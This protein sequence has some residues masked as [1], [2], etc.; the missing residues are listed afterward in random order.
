MNVHTQAHEVKFYNFSY[1][2]DKVMHASSCIGI[3]LN[4]DRYSLE[5]ENIYEVLQARLA[6]HVS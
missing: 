2:F 3:F 1:Y 6:G 4:T 5:T